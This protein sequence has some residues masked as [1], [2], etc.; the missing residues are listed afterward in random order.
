MKARLAIP[1]PSVRKYRE[2]LG[3]EMVGA[4]DPA[5]TPIEAPDVDTPGSVSAAVPPAAIV[6]RIIGPFHREVAMGAS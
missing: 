1:E 2:P 6:C 5:N 4:P 3:A